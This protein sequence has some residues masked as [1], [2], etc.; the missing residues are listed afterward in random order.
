MPKPSM[1]VEG[2][3]RGAVADGVDVGVGDARGC[4]GRGAGRTFQ[5]QG[6]VDIVSVAHAA[7][8][9]VEREEMET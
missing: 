8:G 2:E 1:G 5:P 6:L 7:V 3:A 9:G 4:C